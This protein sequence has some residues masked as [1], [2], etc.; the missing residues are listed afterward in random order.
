[1]VYINAI[2]G[3]YPELPFGGTKM[4]AYGREQWIQ[5]R[6]EFVNLRLITLTGIKE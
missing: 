4:S 5:G 1:M 2:T 3:I 6:R